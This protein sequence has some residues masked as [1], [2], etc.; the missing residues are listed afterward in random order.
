MARLPEFD[1]EMGRLAAEAEASGEVL[2]YVGT[3]DVQVCCVTV[4]VRAP[5]GDAYVNVQCMLFGYCVHGKGDRA[6]SCEQLF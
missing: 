2:R 4:Y 6:G 5:A 1:A 3:V